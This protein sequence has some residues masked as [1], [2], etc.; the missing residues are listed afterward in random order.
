ME[1]A[2]KRKAEEELDVST[3][4]KHRRAM[5][6]LNIEERR[7]AIQ[8][9]LSEAQLRLAEARKIQVEAMLMLVEGYT[10]LCHGKVIDDEG[11]RA[12]KEN[13]Q[14]IAAEI[15]NTTPAAVGHGYRRS[16]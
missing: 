2:R 14:D 13:M 4:K 1:E 7:A 16:P 9:R 5:E 10:N 6:D 8:T 12:F 3:Q 15:N 11:R